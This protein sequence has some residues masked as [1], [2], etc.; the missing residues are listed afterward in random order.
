MQLRDDFNLF[1]LYLDKNVKI[2]VD[3]SPFKVK[4]PTIRDFYTNDEMNAIYHL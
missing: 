2:Y 4:V 1:K 3:N